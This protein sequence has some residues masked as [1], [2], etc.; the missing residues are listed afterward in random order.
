MEE[1]LKAEAGLIFSH[2]SSF[3]DAADS[4][5]FKGELLDLVSKDINRINYLMGIYDGVKQKE[6]S[7]HK[8][9]SI[10]E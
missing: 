6:L 8:L 1:R 9:N 10:G 2:V 7:S 5:K 4:G 3:K